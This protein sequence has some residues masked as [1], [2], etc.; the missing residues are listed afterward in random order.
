MGNNRKSKMAAA[1]DVLPCQYWTGEAGSCRRG[2]ACRDLHFEVEGVPGPRIAAA[3]V[4]GTAR[5]H[6]ELGGFDAGW[7]LK[8]MR[9]LKEQELLSLEECLDALADAGTHRNNE[10]TGELEPWCLT[11]SDIADL[12]EMAALRIPELQHNLIGD[13]VC[14]DF[15]IDYAQT[16][17][18]WTI[19]DP[20]KLYEFINSHLHSTEKRHKGPGSMSNELRACMPFIKLL[21]TSF[22]EG[23]K[24]WGPYVGDVWRGIKHAFPKPEQHDPEKYFYPDR[25]FFW[26]DFKA[27]S[28]DRNQ[29]V[30]EFCGDNGPRTL[31]HIIS[32]EGFSVR[33]FSQFPDEDE[34]VFLIG[35]K[36]VVRGVRKRL[37]PVDLVAG[38]GGGFPVG[39]FPDEID[40]RQLPTSQD[41]SEA[42]AEAAAAAENHRQRWLDMGLEG[43]GDVRD[44]R[45]SRAECYAK[46]AECDENYTLAWYYLG[47]TGGGE[48]RGERYNKTE[49]YIK[50]LGCDENFAG[51]WFNLGTEG[52]GEVRGERY[53]KAQCYIKALGCDENDAKAWTNLGWEGGGEVRGERYNK[54]ACYIKALGCDENNAYAWNLLGVEGGGEVRGE[55]YDQAACYIKA[56]EC[57]EN[58]APAWYN[59]GTVGGGE[60]R[61][62]RCNKAECYIKAL[63]CNENYAWAWN[64]LGHVGGGEVNGERYNEAACRTIAAALGFTGE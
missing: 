17:Y 43:G 51:V 35:A 33:L 32:C 22:D 55:R 11:P 63:G 62:Q 7:R 52:G 9:A 61:G 38:A 24:V 54:V 44:R 58:N 42:A 12:K 27:S 18:L 34:V 20:I 49:C 6:V 21:N 5:G 13:G 53:N 15:N 29:A 48:V 19:Q 26:Y 56:L 31:L 30:D 50:A 1:A 57:D 40:I 2:V 25:V 46:A 45:Y 28:K 37:R 60:V 10:V 64:G 8:I 4:P 23:I 16:I 36:L 59:L 39:G 47:N 3:A 41:P 14:P